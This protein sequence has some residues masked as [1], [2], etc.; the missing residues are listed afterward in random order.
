MNEEFKKEIYDVVR[1]EVINVQSG[2]FFYI[3][4]I[5]VGD[6]KV[7]YCISFNKEESGNITT[8]IKKYVNGKYVVSS[9][10]PKRER[11]AILYAEAEIEDSLPNMNDDLREAWTVE[12]LLGK[13]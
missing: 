9:S 10:I 11:S 13:F 1:R 7:E 8:E 12:D 5:I 2:S 4:D 6:E 3:N